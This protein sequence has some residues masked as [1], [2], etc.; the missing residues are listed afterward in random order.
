MGPRLLSTNGVQF[1]YLVKHKHWT[2][3]KRQTV[4]KLLLHLV[5]LGGDALVADP[6]VL[7]RLLHYAGVRL[8]THLYMPTMV[9]EKQ[10]KKTAFD[11]CTEL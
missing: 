2:Q 1:L 8:G 4:P 5:P 7:P 11:I 9:I 6:P 3:H 10:V